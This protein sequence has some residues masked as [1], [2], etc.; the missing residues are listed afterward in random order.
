MRMFLMLRLVVAS[1]AVCL[2]A[3]TRASI[4]GVYSTSG[5]PNSQKHLQEHL[6]QH[7]QLCDHKLVDSLHARIAELELENKQ[8]KGKLVQLSQASP[9][10][11]E[12][13]VH[14]SAKH[15][16]VPAV[17]AAFAKGVGPTMAGINAT[18]GAVAA[19]ASKDSIFPAPEM[20]A[21]LPGQPFLPELVLPPVDGA[22]GHVTVPG[23]N[24]W[25]T[26][27]AAS[28]LT[29][30]SGKVLTYDDVVFGYNK[31]WQDL[32][33]WKMQRW[34]GIRFF[35][36][37]QDALVIQ[38]LIWNVQP[39]LLIEIGTHAGGSAVF[40]SEVMQSYNPQ[41]SIVT[42]DPDPSHID[43]NGLLLKTP[44]IKYLQGM[45]HDPNIY[46]QVQAACV[47]RKKVMVMHDGDHSYEGVLRDIA[48]YDPLVSVG[49]YMIV[50][51]TSL[52]RTAPGSMNGALRAIQAFVSTP[53]GKGYGRYGIDKA[54]EY[55][56]FSTNHNGYL[57]KVAV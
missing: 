21:P 33:L 26:P 19:V 20:P 46:Q 9:A 2:A 50:Q 34:K 38:Q 30:D 6:Q 44:T 7:P 3:A 17:R 42:M 43:P 45:S 22:L 12:A 31:L 15:D 55:L 11:K 35:Q 36:A 39:D 54:Y 51:D 47:G 48:L 24:Q 56:M 18:N 32:G 14:T 49:S 53:G 13:H 25:G 4:R 52:D 40:L 29:I 1:C 8:L 10:P 16:T 37:P 5:P 57:K 28:T 41:A 27:M 23:S